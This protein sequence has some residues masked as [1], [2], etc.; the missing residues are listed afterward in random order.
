MSISSTGA[1]TAV[2]GSPVA[3]VYPPIYIAV[4]P[5]GSFV[6]TFNEET[7]Q[8]T[9][10]IVVDPMEGYAL[11]TTGTLTPVSGSPFTQETATI[12]EFDQ[13]GQYI[14]AEGGLPGSSVGGTFAYSANTTTGALDST[15]PHAGAPPGHF[16]VTDLP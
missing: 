2:S 16:A 15:L 4:S 10:L 12:G 11:S 14:F 1:L 9:N 3:T 6:Y 5:N 7:D 8:S 13:S